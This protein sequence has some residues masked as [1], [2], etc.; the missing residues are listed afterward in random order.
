MTFE[1][2]IKEA[3]NNGTV[4][5]PV[6][7]ESPPGILVLHGSEGG[8]SGWSHMRS[9]WLAQY[10]GFATS[11]C[12]GSPT[13]LFGVSRGAEQAL[14]LASLMSESKSWVPE[15]VV[16]HAASDVVAGPFVNTG[17]E[18]KEGKKPW[19]WRGSYEHVQPDTPIPIEK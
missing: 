17:D 10:G 3:P 2:E 14:L 8:A 11:I 13:G 1:V 16:A 5:M 6:G 12:K 18:T 9:L 7:L 19:K 15:A 4:F